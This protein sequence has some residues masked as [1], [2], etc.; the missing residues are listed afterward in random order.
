MYR[1]D[2]E[3]VRAQLQ[4]TRSVLD[5][6]LK[7]QR[8]DGLLGRIPWW[9]FVD[10]G[11]DFGFG[12]PP[13]E[14]DGESSVL[15]LQ[16]IEALRYAVDIENALGDSHNAAIYRAAADRAAKGIYGR[17]WNPHYGL[18]ADTPAQKHFSQHAN[19]L[20]IWLA[21]IPV[22]E[23][24]KVL[25]KIL[26][27]SGDASAIGVGEAPPMT[28]ATYYFRFYLARALEHAGR[29]DKYLNLL[30]PWKTMLSLGLTTWA[31]QPEPTR[32]DSH[33]WSAHPNYDFLTIVAGIMPTAPGFK[34][35]TV[36]P[37]LGGLK[38]IKATV[39]VP[40][41]DID[42]EY[43]RKRKGIEASIS[44]PVGVS[45]DLIWKGKTIPLHGRAENL[46]LP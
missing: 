35:V 42:V 11:K 7:R 30:G 18:L 28:L 44:L 34:S 17:C 38:H 16:L 12:E 9:P 41:G 32:S 21:V 22:P 19:I 6:Y 8:P 1:G 40:Q 29:G 39:P 27:A 4:G 31:E 43:T 25:A 20:G 13:Q 46:M 37:H 24:R 5:W 3:F 23:Q 14:T 45:G 36:E 10:W 26:A 33:A 15:T 2:P